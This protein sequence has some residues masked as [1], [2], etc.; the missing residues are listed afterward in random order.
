MDAI[1]AIV[2]LVGILAL[3][4]RLK[5]WRWFW[6]A[7]VALLGGFELTA[8]LVTGKTLSQQ[9]WAYIQVHSVYGWVMVASLILGGVGLGV[10]LA[11]KQIKKR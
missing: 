5:W 2:V 10:H 8:K 4:W 3:W 9:F 7:L 1:I 6:I 11:W